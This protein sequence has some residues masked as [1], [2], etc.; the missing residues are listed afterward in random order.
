MG[1]PIQ[2]LNITPSLSKAYPFPWQINSGG[3]GNTDI[4]DGFCSGIC[5]KWLWE[6]ALNYISELQFC[7]KDSS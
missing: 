5:M 1:T 4:W 2:A 6:G 7:S 3:W